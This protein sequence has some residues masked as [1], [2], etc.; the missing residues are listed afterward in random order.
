MSSH[1]ENK[2]E[3]FYS[4][5]KNIGF[6]N[7]NSFSA[8][9][10]DY[11]FGISETKLF[12]DWFLNNVNENCYLSAEELQEFSVKASKGQVIW[13]LNRLDDMYNLINLKQ[14]DKEQRSKFKSN[15]TLL[16]KLYDD[17]ND[18]DDNLDLD[19]NAEEDNLTLD[20][21]ELIKRDIEAKDREIKLLQ[22]RFEFNKFCQKKFN[23]NLKISKTK[24]E[25][26]DILSSKLD[27]KENYIRNSTKLVNQ[28][29]NKSYVEFQTKLG[30]EE[31]LNQA[32][33]YEEE[34]PNLDNYINLE[35]N[36]LNT[37]N[38]F[39][40][41]ELDCSD[42]KS[43]GNHI[44]LN[45]TTDHDSTRQHLKP[46]DPMDKEKYNQKLF[47]LIMEKRYPKSMDQWVQ[48]KLACDLSKSNLIE[49]NRIIENKNQF[50]EFTSEQLK[51]DPS[52]KSIIEERIKQ[53]KS[54][55]EILNETFNNLARQ[56]PATINDLANLKMVNLACIDMDKKEIDLNLFLNKQEKLFRML[57]SQK[58]RIEFLSFLQN[59]KLNNVENLKQLFEELLNENKL[60]NNQNPLLSTS[61]MMN[62]I[63][64][65]NMTN[66]NQFSN[67]NLLSST[68]ALNVSSSMPS[69]NQ[70]MSSPSKQGSNIKFLNQQ[71]T[72]Q[73]ND[74][75]SPFMHILNQFLISVL[76]KFESTEDL[77]GEN[78]FQL[79][80]PISINF[81][82]NLETY[83]KLNKSVNGFYSNN[84]NSIMLDKQV[85]YFFNIINNAIE[86]LYEKDESTNDSSKQLFASASSSAGLNYNLSKISVKMTKCLEEPLKTLNEKTKELHSMFASK[87]FHQLNNYRSQ[88][89]SNK[90]A[91]LRRNFFVHFYS[92]PKQVEYLMQQLNSIS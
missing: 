65:L 83:I 64:N 87:I 88:L 20:N 90:I 75:N 42:L 28:S 7:I 59:L 56:M 72:E 5:L 43:L 14:E 34:L 27:E 6:Q 79:Q 24:Y 30:D 69:S 66:Y 38:K 53:N 89:A 76:S 50:F 4:L 2:S 48:S 57:N 37:I 86:Y 31:K 68:M 25:R 29:L 9:N 67:A 26:E 13:D 47:K 92:N 16:D 46:E 84:N 40:Y 80:N 11:L 10:F 77:I 35:K 73:F 52:L 70:F 78:L 3:R 71:G 8:N 36:V 61:I 62:N 17:E 51:Q 41:L 55:S 91:Q 12:F 15:K 21:I 39:M 74:F 82:D 63:K 49:M 18:F 81:N 19:F 32:N 58:S 1:F 45:Y 22:E 44:D 33:L 60:T 85:K 54:D 23:D